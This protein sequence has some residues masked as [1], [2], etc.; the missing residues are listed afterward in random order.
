MIL[1]PTRGTLGVRIP[2]LEHARAS[3]LLP[4][5]LKQLADPTGP[6]YVA[7]R[8]DPVLMTSGPMLYA[9]SYGGE[10]RGIGGVEEAMRRR[11]PLRFLEEGG[12]CLGDEILACPIVMMKR[13]RGLWARVRVVHC[14]LSANNDLLKQ[15]TK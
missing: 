7:P 3:C 11:G 10:G 9:A 4:Q 6:L 2:R 8:W 13:E 12:D 5:A 15:Y 1:Q 14:L